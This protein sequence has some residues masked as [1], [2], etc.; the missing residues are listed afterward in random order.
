MP[1]VT[2]DM[3]QE[4]GILVL[5]KTHSLSTHKKIRDPEQ[6]ALALS[7]TGQTA[8]VSGSRMIIHRDFL[9]P[10]ARIRAQARD[11]LTKSSSVGFKFPLMRGVSFVPM[12]LVEKARQRMGEFI[13]AHDS[14]VQDLGANW[15]NVKLEARQRLGV[16]YDEAEY[17][18]DPTSKFKLEFVEFNIT[19]VG[20]NPMMEV[21][22]SF[23]DN[24][25]VVLRNK[26]GE[27]FDSMYKKLAVTYDDE[28]HEQKG[29]LPNNS[30]EKLEEFLTLVRSLDRRLLDD[31]IIE[32]YTGMLDSLIK[33]EKGNIIDPKELKKKSNL[34]FRID[35][36][37]KFA[38]IHDAFVSSVKENPLRGID[39]DED[40]D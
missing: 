23:K 11:W 10:I 4:C 22:E 5:V 28:G 31:E 25:A 18:D 40:D 17:P 36:G 27:I 20:E 21:V 26:L 16:L 13:L 19:N 24:T 30:F 7:Q 1:Q 8:G 32:E 12:L 3:L 9:K 34:D 15:H 2:I 6:E 39:M 33:D 38:D 14:A 37:D 35:L 29:T